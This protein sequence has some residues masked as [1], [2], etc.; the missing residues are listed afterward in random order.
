MKIARPPHD[1]IGAVITDV[2]AP[3]LTSGEVEGVKESLYRD[4]LVVFRD[5]SPSNH[6]YIEL[7]KLFGTPQIYFQSN[8]HHPEHPEI[9]VSSNEL[10]DGK[11]FGVAGTGRYWHTDYSFMTEPLSLTMVRPVRI[12]EGNRGTL[13]TDMERV[14]AELPDSLRALVEGRRAIHE[15]KHRYKVQ[16]KDIDRSLL[17]IMEEIAREVPAVTHPTVIRHPVTRRDSLYVNEGFTTG[18]EGMP[19]EDSRAVLD[20]LFAFITQDRFIHAHPWS[21][22]DV[23][24]WD[25]R[26]LNHM[27]AHGAVIHQASTSFR[28]GVYDG[29]PFYTNPDKGRLVS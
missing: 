17:E 10:Y 6:E 23:L 9:F 2:K 20:Q 27:A 12:P 29:L 26:V 11:K 8:Y 16:A 24:F 3:A 18:L 19:H 22:G 28:I 1:R 25:N 5:Q 21:H 13:Y 14:W 7:A 15:G 4:K